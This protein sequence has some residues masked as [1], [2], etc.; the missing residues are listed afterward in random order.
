LASIRTTIG[1]DI[2]NLLVMMA[3]DLVGDSL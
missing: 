2:E 1:L 3:V